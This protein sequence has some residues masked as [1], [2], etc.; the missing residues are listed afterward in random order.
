MIEDACAAL[1]EFKGSSSNSSL[2]SILPCLNPAYADHVM[3]DIRFGI[4]NFIN[5][6][7]FQSFFLITGTSEK[8]N[9]I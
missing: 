2:K 7:R 3:L 4:H 8:E 1:E 5:K 9:L 6:V